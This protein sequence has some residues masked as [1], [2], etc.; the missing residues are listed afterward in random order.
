MNKFLDKRCYIR[1]AAG[2]SANYK[3]DQELLAVKRLIS[4]DPKCNDY[5]SS[6]ARIQRDQERYR[7]AGLK[8][9]EVVVMNPKDHRA[10][11]NLGKCFAKQ[12]KHEEAIIAYKKGLKIK[13][14][15][16][17]LLN[18]A[19]T[20]TEIGN[21]EE[22]SKWYAKALA[23]NPSNEMIHNCLGYLYFLQGEYQAAIERFDDAISHEPR[24]CVAFFKK[25]LVLFCQN[26]FGGESEEVFRNG[27]LTL[28]G[29]NQQ[30]IQ[31][32]KSC[33]RLYSSDVKRV[34][35]YLKS[36]EVT[37]ERKN[38]LQNLKRDFEHILDLLEREIE[39]FEKKILDENS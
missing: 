35:E 7:S 16:E 34:R 37:L 30:K 29:E 36:L 14:N 5:H 11:N 32:L 4:L 28:S 12:N 38:H 1:K 22:A 2:H 33:V 21:C 23:L 13:T 9:R 24:Y 39:E 26:D 6:W 17:L 20:F 19:I 15:D 8:Y 27:V 25:A 3:L 10:F 18:I 31:R